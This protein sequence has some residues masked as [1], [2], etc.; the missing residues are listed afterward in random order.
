MEA[1]VDFICM[2]M[3]SFCVKQDTDAPDLRSTERVFEDG[4]LPKENE[5][6]LAELCVRKER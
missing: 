1:I 6:Q 3:V 4:L 2:R 5:E